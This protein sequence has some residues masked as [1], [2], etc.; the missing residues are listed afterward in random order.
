MIEGNNPHVLGRRTLFMSRG[1]IAG[2]V[3]AL[4]TLFYLGNSAVDARTLSGN[5][6]RTQHNTQTYFQRHPYQKTGVIGA[7]A[8]A[9]VGAFVFGDKHNRGRNAVKGAALGGAAGLGYEYVKRHG[10]FK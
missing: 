5:A 7:G 8:G 4:S 3:L 6:R 2:L 1:S 10:G 9:A